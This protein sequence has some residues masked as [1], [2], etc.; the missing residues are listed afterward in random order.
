MVAAWCVLGSGKLDL[1]SSGSDQW[2]MAGARLGC[3]SGDSTSDELWRCRG[4]VARLVLLQVWS[5]GG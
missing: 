4:V 2:P 3:Q 5:P 1:D